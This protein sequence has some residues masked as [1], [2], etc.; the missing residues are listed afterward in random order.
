M[1]HFKISGERIR[2]HLY[3]SFAGLIAVRLGAGGEVVERGMARSER[4][5]T[6][7]AERATRRVG[8]GERAS[9]EGESERGE[10]ERDRYT[11]S[12]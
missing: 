3:I 10:D 4:A 9:C 5:P 7:A 2:F 6:G 8:A 11:P 1:P 12:P